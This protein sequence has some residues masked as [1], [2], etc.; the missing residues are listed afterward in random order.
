MELVIMAAGMGSRF[1]GLKQIEPIDEDGNFII[2]YSIYDAIRCGFDKVIFIIKR[3]NY[4]IFKNTVGKR[5]ESQ[6][7][8]EYV[9][10]ETDVSKYTSEPLFEG[11]TK[12]LGTG[13]AVLSA[14]DAV[15]SNFAVINADDYYGYDAVEKIA[16]FLKTNTNENNYSLVCYLL[17]N[18]LSNKET[19]KRGVCN[20][21]NGILTGITESLI[22]FEDDKMFAT[23]ILEKDAQKREISGNEIV[24]VNLFGFPHKFLNHLEFAFKEFL[25]Q[26]PETLKTAE[27]FLPTT[28]SDL[29]KSGDATVE[30]L[31][32]SS[33]W[34]GITYKQ[35]KDKVANYLKTLKTEGIYP[36]HLWKN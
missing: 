21:D 20:C 26:D 1:G 23:P 24:S 12:P 9:F 36:E 18:T 15:E 11:R 3:E 19:L 30:I 25:K 7:K 33:T 4:E 27:F 31:E 14:K 17:G 35:D 32:T 29:I 8:T 2:D 6:I 10:Q 28:V 5:I 16:N 13:H 34:H 22:E